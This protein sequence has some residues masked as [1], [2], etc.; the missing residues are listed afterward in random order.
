MHTS[1]YILLLLGIA[2]HTD[3][4]FADNYRVNVTRKSSNIYKVTNEDIYIETKYCYEYVYYADALLKMNDYTG[5]I[6]F[7]DQETKCDVKSV[8]GSLEIEPGTYDVNV[9]RINDDWYEVDGTGV[10]LRT[11]MCLNLALGEEAILKI[12]SGRTGKLYF[13]DDECQV[14]GVYTRLKL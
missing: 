5:E 8:Y 2:Y 9:T 10:F 7:L 11:S 12:Y 3:I 1:M 13:A 4:C 6:I 14:E